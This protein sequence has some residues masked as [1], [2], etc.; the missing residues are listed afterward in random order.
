MARLDDRGIDPGGTPQERNPAVVRGRD[1]EQD[2]THRVA[3][4]VAETGA[5]TPERR[6]KKG[7][8]MS[9]TSAM[10]GVTTCR[11]FDEGVNE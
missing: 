4:D 2:T 8:V 6:A 1:L 10:K 5:T 3:D 7:V 11:D 9:A